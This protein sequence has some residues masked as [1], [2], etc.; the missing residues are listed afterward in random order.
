MAKITDVNDRSWV[1]PAGKGD[2]T[3]ARR[4]W[5]PSAE[6]LA[7]ALKR[8]SKQLKKTKKDQRRKAS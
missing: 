7:A 4:K 8:R 3:K 6:D 2:Y 5:D 1:P